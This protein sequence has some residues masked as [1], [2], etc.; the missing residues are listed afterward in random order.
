MPE[1]KNM[2]FISP[3]FVYR[4]GLIL[5]CLVQLCTYSVMAQQVKGQVLDAQTKEP[6]PYASILADTLTGYGTGANAQGN[7][8][9]ELSTG[10]NY[11]VI[12]SVGYV[13]RTILLAH[14]ETQLNIQLQ[15]SQTTLAEVTVQAGDN[16]ALRI[17]KQAVDKRKEH[18]LDQLPAYQYT[19]YQKTFMTL[20]A[21]QVNALNAAS[22]DTAEANRAKRLQG[23]A[24]HNYI[25][26]AEDV[27]QRSYL[28]PDLIQDKVIASRFSGIKNSMA[29][30]LTGF[31]KP[32]EFYSNQLSILDKE[33]V[34]PLSA[35]AWRSYEFT[36]TDTLYAEKDTVWVLQY[37]PKTTTGLP[38]VKGTLHIREPGFALLYTTASPAIPGM[39]GFNIEQQWEK[40]EGKYHFPIHLKVELQF[41]KLKVDQVSTVAVSESY[42]QN[43]SINTPLNRQALRGPQVLVHPDALNQDER[44]WMQYRTDSLTAREQ[45]TYVQTDSIMAHSRNQRNLKLLEWLMLGKIPGQWIDID[46]NRLLTFNEWEGTRLGAGF[47]TSPRL[48]GNIALGAYAAYGTRDRALKWGA[49]AAYVY[50]AARSPRIIAAYAKDVQEPGQVQW[51]FTPTAGT[52]EGA[53]YR[54]LMGNR[55]DAVHKVQLR[56][57]WVAFPFARMAA[58]L[59]RQDIQAL[60]NYLYFQHLENGASGTSQFSITEAT[61][62]FNYTRGLRITNLGGYLIQ[63]GASLPAWRLQLSRGLTLGAHGEYSYNALRFLTHHRWRLAGAGQ[64]ELQSTGGITKDNLPYP[65][66]FTGRGTRQGSWLQADGYF[67]TMGLYEFTSSRHA[68]AQLRWHIGRIAMLTPRISPEL[69]LVQH[70]GIGW[71]FNK[72]SHQGI[73]IKSMEKGFHEAG[74]EMANL[75]RFNY[76]NVAYLGLG[77]GFYYRY[78][79]YAHSLPKENMAIRLSIQLSL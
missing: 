23:F 30:L 38:G 14:Y 73:E 1:I 69:A 16:P 2:H 64:L 58:S 62:E 49:D 46:L 9:I 50:G 25:F 37:E 32:F 68:D 41:H 55:M 20:D 8:N 44:V 28:K 65:L 15:P 63:T 29:A 75:Y 76:A 57:E 26:M 4:S 60:Y 72:A 31:F 51:A 61:L 11:L 34:S 22:S 17:I 52:L 71:L 79:S 10:M 39:I 78:G 24:A 3:A 5:L 12:S 35:G 54:S 33:Y 67:Q 45:R 18:R 21:E 42:I 48:F 43:I 40:I 56:T 47:T 6:I 66:L 74:L 19:A 59:L 36:L 7:F 53:T 70:S 77:T 13:R 27:T